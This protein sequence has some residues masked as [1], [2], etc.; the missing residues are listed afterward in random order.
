[1]EK[2]LIAD[3]DATSTEAAPTRHSS[4][5]VASAPQ[6]SSAT[7]AHGTILG[8]PGYMAPE[9]ER[10]EINLIDQRTDVFGLGSLLQYMLRHGESAP[11][12]LR[13][14]CQ[15]AVA[16]E[17]SARYASVQQM[18]ADIGKYLDGMPITAYQE[19]IF[20]RTVRLANRNRVAVALI[21]AYLFMRMLFIL[22]SRR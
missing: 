22:F 7:T 13:A 11:R 17:M 19:N 12:P 4:S 3:T 20:E 1:A 21:L 6:F 18:A 8:T 16:R 5:T 15:K 9:Q 14:I 10:G 2:S